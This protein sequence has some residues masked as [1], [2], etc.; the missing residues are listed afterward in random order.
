[1]DDD[2]LVPLIET[3]DFLD[4]PLL[5]LRQLVDYDH[6]DIALAQYESL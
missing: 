4:Q 1:V 3:F 6:H 2:D 5:L